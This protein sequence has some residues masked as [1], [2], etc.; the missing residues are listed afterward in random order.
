MRTC[1]GCAK[2]VDRDSVELARGKHLPGLSTIAWL[3]RTSIT[4]INREKN[5]SA[6]QHIIEWVS[7][8]ANATKK[9]IHLLSKITVRPLSILSHT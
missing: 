4:L 2:L 5:N 6:Y 9:F 8:Q 1:Y 3:V 7:D